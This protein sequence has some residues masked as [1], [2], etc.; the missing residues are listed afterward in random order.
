MYSFLFPLAFFGVGEDE[1]EESA[2]V[3]KGAVNNGDGT[4]PYIGEPQ[5]VF[6]RLAGGEVGELF[7]SVLELFVLFFP[8]S[9]SKMWRTRAFNPAPPLEVGWLDAISDL[10]VTIGAGG[11]KTSTAF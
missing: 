6:C 8:A 4:G 11:G 2:G 7:V 10:I 9:S 5:L 3:F 1:K